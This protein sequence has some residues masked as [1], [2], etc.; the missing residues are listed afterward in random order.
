MDGPA[1][2]ASFSVQ[3]AKDYLQ[4][5]AAHFITQ[6]NGASERLHG[7]NYRVS[8]RLQGTL[9]PEMGYVFDFVQLKTLVRRLVE[10]LDHRV[11]LA[12]DNPLLPVTVSAAEP[13]SAPEGEEEVRVTTPDGR[14]YVFPRGDVV[15]LPIANTTA[16]L[17]AWHLAGRLRALLLHPAR[18]TAP[19]V[20]AAA[21]ARS[22]Q[23]IEVEVEETPGQ[24][25]V[26]A[27]RGDEGSGTP[28]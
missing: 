21:A 15:L 17:L 28:W 19:A 2:T 10:E 27:Q 13:G 9:H 6:E 8:V 24:T 26:C 4:F 23:S 20:T 22:I 3:V 1:D 25:A 12:L 11:L 18:D 5:C 16:E 14:R 7:H